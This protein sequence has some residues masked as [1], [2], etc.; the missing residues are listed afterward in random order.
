MSGLHFHALRVAERAR[1]ADDAITL[2][3]E[4]PGE[5]REAFAFVPG[6]H[7]TLRATVGGEELRRTYSV[8][9]APGEPLL[10]IGVRRVS[11]GVFS[12]WLHEHAAVGSRI[13]ALP[14]DGRF[15]LPPFDGR[16]RHVLAV[17][18]GSGITPLLAIVKTLL[19]TE[20]AS[21]ATLLYG[22]RS[23]ASAMFMEA[24][25]DLKNRYL[26]R[27][28]LHPVFSRDPTDV[29]LASGRIDAAKIA[30]FARGVIDLRS[31]DQ[32]FVCGPYQMNDE[33][34]SA[35]RAAGVSEERIHVE[36]FGVP[37][38]EREAAAPPRPGD[39]AQARIVLIRDGVTR[40]IDFRAEHGNLL[41]AARAAGIDAPFSCKSG[42]CSTCRAKLL[43]GRVRMDRNF[44]LE[45][46]DLAAGFVLTCQ[47][48]PL[49]PR[50]VLSYDER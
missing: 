40:E 48:H 11:G 46:A 4:V 13:D 39:A 26:A 5:L 43:E 8:C 27:F 35:L 45:Q 47:A 3:F 19:A 14:P 23:A 37:G 41:A 20:P 7:L 28:A 21:R 2:A 9:S 12:T 30:A 42:M 32:A 33:V 50:L 15:V 24:L 29:P 31:V 25:E 49:T 34:A 16:P 17:A 1:E 22:N 10:R 44:A 18:G 36:R 6:Q 38:A